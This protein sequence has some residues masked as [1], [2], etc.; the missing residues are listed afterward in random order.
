VRLLPKLQQL[1]N[2]KIQLASNPAVNPF[3]RLNSVLNA[4]T[5]KREEYRHL[6]LKGKD[7]PLW[8]KGCTKEFARLAQGRKKSVD[9]GTNSLHSCIQTYYQKERRQP[10][11]PSVLTIVPKR[12][13]HIAYNSLLVATLSTTTTKP[14]RPLLILPPQN[15]SCTVSSPLLVSLSSALTFQIF[16]SSHLFL[17]PANMNISTSLNG[18]S[19]RISCKNTTLPPHQKQTTPC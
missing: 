1:V 4:D 19:L 15:S 12:P 2:A 6:V 8:E 10:L 3:Y 5:G 18:P 7:K 11:F 14:T 17:T 16:T 13:T 9:K